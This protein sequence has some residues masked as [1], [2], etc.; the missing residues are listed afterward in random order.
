MKL[1]FFRRKYYKLYALITGHLHPWVQENVVK[2][3][4]QKHENQFLESIEA[5]RALLKRLQKV[6]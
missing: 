6:K 5:N 3:S 4:V 2:P 1:G